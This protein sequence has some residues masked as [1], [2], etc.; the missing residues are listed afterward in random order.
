MVPVTVAGYWFQ[1]RVS[2]VT[3]I[4]VSGVAMGGLLV[5]VVTGVIDTFG[6]RTAMA[7][8]GY[9]TWLIVLPLSLVVRHHPERYGM[10]PDGVP[11]IEPIITKAVKPAANAATNLA[12]R[13]GL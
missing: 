12:P 5:P 9:A 6:W 13:T 10:F 4:I 7:L 2:L 1:R 8:F 3:G 11:G